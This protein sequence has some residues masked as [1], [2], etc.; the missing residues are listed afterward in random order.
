MHGHFLPSFFLTCSIMCSDAPARQQIGELEIGLYKW[1]RSVVKVFWMIRALCM[2]VWV[3]WCACVANDELR[4]ADP[5][6]R[7]AAQHTSQQTA[8][9][10]ILTCCAAVLLRILDQLVGVCVCKLQGE[11]AVC[12]RAT[13][14]SSRVFVCCAA[15]LCCATQPIK[16]YSTHTFRLS[17][18]SRTQ[19]TSPPQLAWL[20]FSSSLPA[21]SYI[22]C[23]NGRHRTFTAPRRIA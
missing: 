10:S 11:R 19:A 6:I 15:V 8:L 21:S 1:Q 22:I 12:M 2:C 16:L 14:E 20:T 17:R 13:Y 9:F 4:C 3:V 7:Q 5:C 23:L 18:A